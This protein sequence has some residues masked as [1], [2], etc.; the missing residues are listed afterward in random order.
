[1]SILNSEDEEYVLCNKDGFYIEENKK[2]GYKIIGDDINGYEYADATKCDEEG[3]VYY[4]FNDEIATEED[5]YSFYN[6]VSDKFVEIIEDINIYAKRRIDFVTKM[7]ESFWVANQKEPKLLQLASQTDFTPVEYKIGYIKEGIV[8]SD[9]TLEKYEIESSTYTFS[10][11]NRLDVFIPTYSPNQFSW[12]GKTFVAQDS[13]GNNNSCGNVIDNYVKYKAPYLVGMKNS[14]NNTYPPMKAQYFKIE[15]PTYIGNEMF[16]LHFID[17]PFKVEFKCIAALVDYPIIATN[18]YELF[19]QS[20]GYINMDSI[21]YDCKVHN[22]AIFYDDFD[23]N[24]FHFEKQTLNNTKLKMNYFNGINEDEYVIRNVVGY[25]NE[26]D[27]EGIMSRQSEEIKTETISEFVCKPYIENKK[28][29]CLL[30][31]TRTQLIFKDNFTTLNETIYGGMTVTVLPSKLDSPELNY[32][33]NN[34]D[35]NE[36]VW[37]TEYNAQA[38]G[39]D[40]GEMFDNKYHLFKH[41]SSEGVNIDTLLADLN[42]W[43]VSNQWVESDINRHQ[44][45]KPSK[46]KNGSIVCCTSAGELV[47]W[48][49]DRQQW[50]FLPSEATE[51]T[52]PL[53]R[54]LGYSPYILIAKTQ[55]NCYAISKPFCKT[56][57]L[58]YKI[59]M[60]L[61]IKKNNQDYQ[62]VEYHKGNEKIWYTDKNCM[63]IYQYAVANICSEYSF[64]KFALHF[65]MPTGY[66][67]D[68]KLRF[69][70][71]VGNESDGDYGT[72]VVYM[73]NNELIEA[74]NNYSYNW[75]GK[76]PITTNQYFILYINDNT[77]VWVVI[78]DENDGIRVADTQKYKWRVTKEYN[79]YKLWKFQ[80]SSFMNYWEVININKLQKQIKTNEFEDINCIVWN[81]DC[82]E[83]IDGSLKQRV[84]KSIYSNINDYVMSDNNS[85]VNFDKYTV[86]N[87]PFYGGEEYSVNSTTV[88]DLCVGIDFD[89]HRIQINNKIFS[90]R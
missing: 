65:K 47:D 76:M 37:V 5:L 25:E 22:G 15:N 68:D 4:S 10:N 8:D 84:G 79:T 18:A 45:P 85:I 49:D 41:K 58:V 71:R 20:R 57:P 26:W 7:Q 87:D 74:L 24:D 77:R 2:D 51:T 60:I 30:P 73:T 50:Y 48:S 52:C 31:P 88:H 9:E 89:K 21:L 72:S 12:D 56:T 67:S 34:G 40:V 63:K 39:F 43:E 80:I 59:N 69:V 33:V 1:M 75:N 62:F 11:E 46:F 81:G 64:K 19:R 13:N 16:H 28:N 54:W 78:N 35:G 66:T 44:F 42:P 90:W 29:P 61:Y 14:I 55:N 83:V 3:Y 36:D 38:L 82:F 53:W 32:R 23:K 86:D 17:K 6:T 27:C 70:N